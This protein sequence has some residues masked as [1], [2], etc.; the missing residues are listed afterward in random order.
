MISRAIGKTAFQAL[1]P[2]TL[3]IYS[4]Y[5]TWPLSSVS[6]SLKSL[7][8]SSALR[9]R[10]ISWKTFFSSALSNCILMSFIHILLAFFLSLW[11]LIVS[12][13]ASDVNSKRHIKDYDQGLRAFKEISIEPMIMQYNYHENLL[14]VGYLQNKKLLK[15]EK[16]LL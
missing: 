12:L 10:P 8:T 1:L 4:S 15:M 6:H 9:C 3:A 13:P 11:S 7:S 14:L 2:K 5:S 16:S